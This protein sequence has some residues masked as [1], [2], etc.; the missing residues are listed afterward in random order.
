[1]DFKNT[2]HE[3]LNI[4]TIELTPDKVVLSMP[5]SPQT[6]QPMGFL[7]GGAS[8]VLAESAASMGTNL[9]IDTKMQVA[10]G[11]EINANHLR[12]I[13]DGIVQAIATPIHKGKM[14]MVW[15]IEIKDEAERIIC[16]SRCTVGI[17][18]KY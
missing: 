10:M 16:V 3:A 4:E 15:Q 18:S 7:H 6:R 13:K 9:N 14:T 5:V 17:V 8:V 11:I 12:S 2:I 1:M